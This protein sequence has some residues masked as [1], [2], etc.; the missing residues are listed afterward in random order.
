MSNKTVQTEP[1]AST[2][3][4][5]SADVIARGETDGPVFVDEATESKAP[6]FETLDD[7]I[8]ALGETFPKLADML[9]TAQKF[10]V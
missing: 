8:S 1:S 6:R 2:E 5:Q 9:R 3:A 7:E 10:F 4:I